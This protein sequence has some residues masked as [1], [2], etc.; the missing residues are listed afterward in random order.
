VTLRKSES[1]RSK[2]ICSRENAAGSAKFFNSTTRQQT[3]CRQPRQNFAAAQI[4]EL[5]PKRHLDTNLTA[6][7][8]A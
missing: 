2:K 1:F 7:D 6:G 3:L 4:R 5:S 8:F